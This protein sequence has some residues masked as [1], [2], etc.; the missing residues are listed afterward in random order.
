MLRA[1]V[2]LT[3]LAA[4]ALPLQAQIPAAIGKIIGAANLPVSADS[5][6]RE[7]IPDTD[8]RTAIE[9]MRTA[10]LPAEEAKRVLDES[11]AAQR[12]HGPVDNFGAFVQ[13]RLAAGLRGR[14]LAAAIRAE[15]RARGKGNP[16]ATKGN[17][18]ATKGN[19]NA[20]KGRS[21]TAG[22]SRGNQGRGGAGRD[23]TAR[24]KAGNPNRPGQG[25][26][27]QSGKGQSKR[28]DRPNR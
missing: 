21:D 3:L 27:A 28:P 9:A 12:E 7:G 13:S 18:N 16:N 2:V 22:Q 17:R 20:T 11:R 15:H 8:V 25:G 6:R 14:E 1:P 24:G 23:T 5:A 26:G 19:P 4:A 10:R